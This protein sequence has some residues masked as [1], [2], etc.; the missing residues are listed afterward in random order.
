MVNLTENQLQDFS[1]FIYQ[2][3][4]QYLIPSFEQEGRVGE[5]EKEM[6]KMIA[7]VTSVAAAAAYTY[8]K[9]IEDS[10]NSQKSPFGS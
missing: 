5:G 9:N 1:S 10:S 2:F 4:V 6:I 3:V 8:L 7:S